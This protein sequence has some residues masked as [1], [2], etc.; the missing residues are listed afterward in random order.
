MRNTAC[1]L[2]VLRTLLRG[3]LN[4]GIEDDTLGSG[5]GPLLEVVAEAD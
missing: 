2:G 3:A 5:G 1:E 4:L